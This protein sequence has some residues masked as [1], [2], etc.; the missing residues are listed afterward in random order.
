VNLS[1]VYKDLF[2][3]V[4][5]ACNL[6]KEAFDNSISSLDCLDEESYKESIHSCDAITSK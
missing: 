6:S 1:I 5:K 2:G 4:E 3:D